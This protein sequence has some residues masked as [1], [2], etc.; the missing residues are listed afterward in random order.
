MR[1]YLEKKLVSSI[2]IAKNNNGEIFGVAFTKEGRK[3]FKIVNL[4][5]FL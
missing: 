4:D 2:E 3:K 5:Y 1:V